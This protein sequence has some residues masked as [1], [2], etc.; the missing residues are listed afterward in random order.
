MTTWVYL[1]GL[2][3]KEP[4]K[5]SHGLI[6]YDWHWLATW[7]DAIYRNLLSR[8]VQQRMRMKDI[9]RAKCVFG[10]GCT[11][12]VARQGPTCLAIYQLTGVPSMRKV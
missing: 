8:M 3:V 7:L 6:N 10:I 2:K 4:G 12:V 1:L 5:L 9:V 11:V